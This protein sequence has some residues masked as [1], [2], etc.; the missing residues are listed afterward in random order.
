[1]LQL[2]L[3]KQKTKKYILLNLVYFAVFLIL[4]TFLD[5]FNLSY[6]SMKEIYG[7]WLVAANIFLNILMALLS[8]LMLG[9]TTAQFDFSGKQSKGSSV[10][11]L[12][13]VFGIFTYGCTPCVISFLASVGITFS[14][15]V[16]PLANLPY[17]LLSLVLLIA[18][19]IYVI[20]AI[21]RTV[22]KVKFSDK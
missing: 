17:K 22:C 16:L 11:F 8:A 14:V 21:K 15:A 10:S 19:M 5:S 12:S 4:Y 3:Q 20:F 1:M 7:V 6:S 18:G 2:V 13:F 9:F